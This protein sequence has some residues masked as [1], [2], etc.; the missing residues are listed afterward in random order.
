M[1]VICFSGEELDQL[2]DNV[3]AFYRRNSDRY[4]L[5]YS[6]AAQHY[7]EFH[8]D[9]TELMVILIDRC[10]WYMYLSNKIAHSLQYQEE[11]EF[12]IESKEPPFKPMSIP[13]LLKRLYSIEYNIVTNDGNKFIEPKFYELFKLIISHLENKLLEPI[14]YPKD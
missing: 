9:K 11:P 7:S 14:I 13:E 1:S 4:N 8:K 3:K 10:F 5:N 12:F 2:R 6:K